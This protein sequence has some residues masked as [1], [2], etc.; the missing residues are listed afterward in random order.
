M[1]LIKVKDYNE[2]SKRACSF[3]IEKVNNMEKPVLGLATGSTPEGLYQNL[4]EKYQKQEVTFDH[5][6]TFNLDEYVGLKKDDPNSYDYYMNENLFK[7][8]GIPREQT[9]LPSGDAADLSQEA[10]QYE[11]LIQE[12]GN[13]DVQ[14]LGLGLNGHIGFNEPGT[15]FSSRTHIVQ[16][17]ESTRNANARF[18]PTIEDVPKQAITM[19]IDTIMQSKMIVLLVSGEKKAN[20]LSQLIDGEVTEAFPASILQTHSNVMIIADQAACSKL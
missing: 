3:I 9:H 20:A 8:I 16:L 5:V 10:L 14:I 13:I 2:M 1:E 11:S 18:F 7:H 15:Q 19:G 12:A 6:Q 17:D 4:I